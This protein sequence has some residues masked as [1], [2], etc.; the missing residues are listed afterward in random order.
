[1]KGC[2]KSKTAA[3]KWQIG[4]RDREKASLEKFIVYVKKKNEGI[5]IARD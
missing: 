3:R 1:M 5:W 2:W 4:H